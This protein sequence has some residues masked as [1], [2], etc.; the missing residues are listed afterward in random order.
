MADNNG[1]LPKFPSS[2]WWDLRRQFRK[3]I[4]KGVV[5]KKYLSSIFGIGEPAA[6]NLIPP[7]KQL[8]LLDQEG[9]ASD[10]ANKWRQDETYSEVCKQILESVYPTGLRD[11]EPGPDVDKTKASN[12]IA[13]HLKVGDSAAGQMAALYALIVEADPTKED[14]DAKPKGTTDTPKAKKTPAKSNTV[15][16]PGGR[17]AATPAAATPEQHTTPP[18]P[19]A[20]HPT[21]KVTPSVHIDVQ[22]HISPEAT[23]EQ[24]EKIFESMGKHI[25]GQSGS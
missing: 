25:F 24:I 17:S 19:A 4:P 2:R 3:S 8:G 13:S 11:V 5:D 23:N 16:Q 6:N 20:I 21:N 22:I 9:K 15:G 7:L 10:L 14:Q 18:I 12:W 1:T